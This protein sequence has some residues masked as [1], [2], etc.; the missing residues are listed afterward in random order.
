MKKSFLLCILAGLFLILTNFLYCFANQTV[1]VSYIIGKDSS[2]W[3]TNLSATSN[4]AL[5]YST[6]LGGTSNSSEKALAITVDNFGNTYVTGS[7]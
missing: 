1:K 5:V 4:P 6:Y 2:K 3:Q 7:C